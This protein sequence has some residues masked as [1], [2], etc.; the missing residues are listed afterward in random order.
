MATSK[1]RARIEEVRKL[2]LSYPTDSAAYIVRILNIKDIKT[3]AGLT[4]TE[5]KLYNF[6]AE[7]GIKYRRSISAKKVV[8]E[9]RLE[10]MR[11][12]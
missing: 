11:L 3:A 7:K 5:N 9:M 6:M 1:D 8:E 10:S 12:L 4:W 2:A